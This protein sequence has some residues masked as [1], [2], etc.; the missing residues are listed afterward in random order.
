MARGV[1][2]RY[3]PGLAWV[4]QDHLRRIVL[5]ERD[6]AGAAN[7][8]LIDQ[9]VR[10]ALDEGFHV[11]CEGILFTGH[12]GSMLRRLIADH[13]GSSF[14]YYFEVG[15]DE[16]VR[17]HLTR[18]QRAAFTPA[19]MREWFTAGDLLGVEDETVV[20]ESSSLAET[21][22]AVYVAA[23]EGAPRRAGSSQA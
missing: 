12:Y 1:R 3:G 7:I 11:V 20:P 6:R 16:T 14:V 10:F 8:A 22:T 23:L 13:R 19:Q 17:R 2:D 9:T 5:Q 21:I 15:F 18:P 4:E